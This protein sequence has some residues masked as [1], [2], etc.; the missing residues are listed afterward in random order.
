MEASEFIKENPAFIKYITGLI[1]TSGICILIFLARFIFKHQ[2][3]TSEKV[4]SWNV[5]WTDFGL[6]IWLILIWLLFSFS[7]MSKI[8]ADSD[9]SSFNINQ[10]IY[11]G[12][13]MH[14][15]ILIIL[16][17]FQKKNKYL[18]F[19]ESLN[20][21]KLPVWKSMPLGLFI[22]FCGFPFIWLVS[23]I[24][25]LILLVLKKEGYPV[26]LEAQPIIEIFQQLTSV[27]LF[28]ALSF[29]A[30]VSAPIT[31]ELIFRGV[32]YRFLKSKCS[33]R[34]S[35]LASAVLFA[36][37]HY[38]IASFPALV[39]VGLCLCIAYEVSGNILTPIFF[40]SFFNLNSVILITL[41][42]EF[43]LEFNF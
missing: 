39:V 24:W 29:L 9:D 15:G 22:F 4:I 41:Q 13:S 33:V 32:I 37:M 25:G 26:S 31:E 34:L 7:V 14:V 27:K 8:F 20:S 40:H 10:I 18:H 35:M 43:P 2:G 28:L 30:V 5:K 19:T 23:T 11:G 1:I 3:Q 42:P 17:L 21:I 38:N 16:Y 36:L 6:L 12:F